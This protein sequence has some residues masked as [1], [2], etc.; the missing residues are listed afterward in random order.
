MYIAVATV[1]KY[2][3]IDKNFVITPMFCNISAFI[4]VGAN[5]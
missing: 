2:G 1:L 4:G 3:Y 5:L